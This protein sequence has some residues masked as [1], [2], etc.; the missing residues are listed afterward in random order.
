MDMAWTSHGHHMDQTIAENKK[1]TQTQNKRIQ[2]APQ[3][4]KKD[5][6]EKN[7]SPEYI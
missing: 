3:N 7:T 2:K 1:T 6:R 5:T 4:I